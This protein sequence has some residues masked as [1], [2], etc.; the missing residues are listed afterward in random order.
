MA[1]RSALDP[2]LKLSLQGQLGVS[3][4]FA[5]IILGAFYMLYWKPATEE[6]V[7]KEAQLNTLQQEIRKLEA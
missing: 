4:L 7:A 3:A 2:L 5:A 6:Q 1:D